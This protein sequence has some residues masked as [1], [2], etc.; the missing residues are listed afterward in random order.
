MKMMMNWV[1]EIGLVCEDD[2]E[3]GMMMNWFWF[4]DLI[5]VLLRFNFMLLFFSS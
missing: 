2:D 5:L 4:V 3:L 1:Y